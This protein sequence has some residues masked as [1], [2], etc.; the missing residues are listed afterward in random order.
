M[1]SQGGL[2]KLVV[3]MLS[4]LQMEAQ[5]RIMILDGAIG[6]MLQRNT[7]AES[8]YR[9]ER[10][11]DR[12]LYPCDLL[13][14]NDILALTRPD[15]VRAVHDGYF[16]AGADFATA[17][18]FSSSIFGQHK[19]FYQAAPCKHDQAYYEAVLADETLAALVRDI[20]VAAVRLAREAA[21]AA[22][23]RDGRK[24]YVLGA[25]GPMAVMA[26]MSSDV[27][28]PAFRAVNFDQLR[29]V[30][31][32]QALCLMEQRLDG[33]ILETTFDTLN[34]KA[35]LFALDELRA[36]GVS[37]PP[38]MLSVT[39]TDRAGRTL[40]GQTVEAF[41]NSVRHHP[42]FS[43]G[44]N[45]SMG[46][47]LML[48]FA[49]EL[50]SLADCHI[51][52]FPNAGMPD[53]FSPS[54]YE[55][56]AATMAHM[57]ADY[58]DKGLLN[59][60]GGC[61]GTTPAHIDAIAQAVRPFAPRVHAPRPHPKQL[62]LS[63][64]EPYNHDDSG[65]TLFVGER[66]N[67]AGSP[68]FAKLIRAGEFEKAL[69]VARRQVENGAVVLDICFDDGMID[70]PATMRHFVNLLSAEPDIAR[71]PFMID[72][73]RWEVLEAGLQCLQGKGIVNSISLK[74]GEA[75]FLRMARLIRRYGAAVVVMGFDEDG[76]AEG[77]D[78]RLR[79]A[80]RAH[81]LL[82]NVV[83]FEE[84]DIIFDPNVLP[85]GTGIAA[86]ADYARDFIGGVGAI[87]ER[88]PNCHLSGG[89]SN[90]SFAFRGMNPVR[91]A[92]H[93]AFLYHAQQ[94][95]LDISIVNAG[96]LAVY[97]MVEP[98]LLQ[99]VEDVL[100]N[101]VEDAT[102]KLLAFAQDLNQAKDA[103]TEQLQAWRLLPV[104]ERLSY[105]L[106]K[107]ITDFIE[108]DTQ[109]ALSH[110][111]HPLELIEGP[112]M[113]GM[114]Q[115]GELFGAGKMFLPQVVKSARVMKQSVALISPL[116][117]EGQDSS[118]AVGTVVLATVKGDVHDIGK[119][120]VGVVLACNGFRVV[121]L[122]V[123]VS[124]EDI[125]AS[126]AAENADLVVVS[127]LITPSLEEMV[128]LAQ[129]MQAADLRLPLMVGGATTSPL[130]TALKIAPT[131][132]SGI[133]A[134][135]ADASTIVPVAA[136]LVGREA[137]GYKARH[138]QEQE[139]LRQQFAEKNSPL[140]P[141]DEARARAL[142]I[143]W[144]TAPQP[145]PLR[146]G[147]FTCSTPVSGCVCHHPQPDFEI[148]WS[149]L[150]EHADWGILLRSFEMEA[151][152]SPSKNAFHPDANHQMRREAE[153]LMRDA[154]ELFEQGAHEEWLAAKAVFGLWDAHSQGD[155]IVVEGGTKLHGM[156]QQKVSSKPRLCLSDFVAP[157][158]QGGVIGAM[159][160]SI[161]GADEQAAAFD[162]AND[163]YRAILLPALA[164]MLAESMAECV[165]KR[166]QEYWPAEGSSMIRPACGFPTQ[167]DHAE[168]RIIFDL[169]NASE[170]TT[171]QLTASNM[172][173][174]QASVCALILN[175]PQAQYFSV[176]PV[177][178]DQKED[179]QSR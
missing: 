98:R 120:I 154:H 134:Q 83:G 79:I 109:E 144:A 93:S 25:L 129:T 179:Y 141:L 47:E 70:G 63:G 140:F 160:L 52:I 102:E 169:L 54:G 85:V 157:E 165:Q 172:M 19:Y 156:R 46:A 14:N 53:P 95:G 96:M 173:Q 15:L 65:N 152:W 42:L 72:S 68:I 135:T 176:L 6:T 84:C 61:C 101:R 126:I 73:A 178:E 64:L 38:V 13:N 128:K 37:V 57:L 49:R 143:D 118:A 5:K 86:H 2:A 69:A 151:V 40:S 77:V 28:D 159:Q 56:D 148:P 124:S 71:V 121:D 175:H 78:A 31:R 131:Y 107:G 174:P 29:R 158:G 67:V 18:T 115:V 161:I 136:A 60:V 59:I 153:S 99:L 27:N 125:L 116:I 41:W 8:D 155:D 30:Y 51:C 170:Y 43:V 20:N 75:E 16:E 34:A 22:E 111:Q 1:T 162:A 100:F 177:G 166:I 32:H 139:V 39:I 88:F 91:E 133:V 117:E 89:I 138:L 132:P 4:P 48:P 45:C 104:Q 44:L 24:R 122:G 10:F 150:M 114:S 108:A 90:V 62:R 35:C 113:S 167:P 58:A 80:T 74:N 87:H 130:H 12:E 36:E 82:V 26:S 110:C 164:N 106:V 145:Q 3:I 112:L 163:S 105:A 33:I 146:K 142:K 137:Q 97:D 92:M 103:P 147:V 171:A 9:G 76:M 66:C 50:A 168:K 127:G 119:N 23:A 123:M 55:H 7:L 81:D 94:Q 17:A 11:T 21:D 149:A